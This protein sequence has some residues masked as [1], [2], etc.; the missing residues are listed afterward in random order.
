VLTKT[1][2]PAT[3]FPR[4]SV[5][6]VSNGTENTNG[7]RG[8]PWSARRPRRP[9]GLRPQNLLALLAV[10]AHGLCMVTNGPGEAVVGGR[11]SV[12]GVERSRPV[13]ARQELP[14]AIRYSITSSAMASSIGG[15]SM[16]SVLAVCRLT[17]NANL[18]GCTTGRSAGLAPLRMVPV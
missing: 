14:W 3:Q 11:T 4:R 15:T 5:I 16:P 6:A 10:G 8:I 1:I 9:A 12:I 17:A 7:T 13:V 2:A 18:V